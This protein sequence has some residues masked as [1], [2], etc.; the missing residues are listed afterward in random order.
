VEENGLT[1]GRG[2]AV[3]TPPS[4]QNVD[5]KAGQELLRNVCPPIGLQ[6]FLK[7]S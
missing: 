5:R 1:E 6:R 2:F 3:A 4:M 7:M